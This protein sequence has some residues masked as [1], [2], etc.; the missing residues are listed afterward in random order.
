ML[1]DVCARRPAV[2]AGGVPRFVDPDRWAV[3]R[4]EGPVQGIDAAVPERGAPHGA[5]GGRRDYRSWSAHPREGALV[6]TYSSPSLWSSTSSRSREKMPLAPVSRSGDGTS[7]RET[8]S[9]R[10]VS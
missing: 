6:S 10:R 1:I 3:V 8:G 4:R 9:C 5:A 2:T 7:P